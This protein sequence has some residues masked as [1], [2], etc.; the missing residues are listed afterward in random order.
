MSTAGTISTLL[1][2]VGT[3]MS[4]AAGSL[5]VAAYKPLIVT[6]GYGVLGLLAGFIAIYTFFVCKSTCAC[7]VH[8][9]S[10]FATIVLVSILMIIAGIFYAVG[11]I[12]ADICYDPNGTLLTLA[13]KNGLSGGMAGDTLN[14]Y[15]TCGANPAEPPIGAASMISG[16]VSTVQ[17]AAAQVKSLS[18]QASDANNAPLAG[19]RTATPDYTGTVGALALDSLSL[20]MTYSADAVA[21]LAGVMSCATI[22]PILSTLWTGVC[23]NGVATII[24]IARI[25]IAASVLLFIQLGIGI[26]MRVQAPRCAAPRRGRVRGA[27][28][29]RAH[30]LTRA[31]PL[32]SPTPT[33]TRRC[34]FHPG[35]TSRYWAEEGVNPEGDGA[36][37]SKPGGVTL[38]QSSV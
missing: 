24:G 13:A 3:M 25:L 15:L 30:A 9:I 23:T 35:L 14:Y 31:S 27:P 36:D 5:N 20:H 34:C 33:R 16:I 2:S 37:G 1:D 26:D 6:G 18:D 29:A 11:V 19:L 8:G 10:S 7:C 38:R 4:G 28:H 22:D 21:S 12:G 17:G 32:P